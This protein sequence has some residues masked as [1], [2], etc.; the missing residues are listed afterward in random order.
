MNYQKRPS[1]LY[2]ECKSRNQSRRN[3][4]IYDIMN[5]TINKENELP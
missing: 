1:L 5:T 3:S 4:R 2:V